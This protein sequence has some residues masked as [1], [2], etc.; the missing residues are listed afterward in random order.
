MGFSKEVREKV[1]NK[2]GGKCAYCGCDLP[3]RWQVDHVVPVERHSMTGEY[4]GDG[5]DSID[6]LLPS[7]QS[8]N[9]IKS[10]QPLES[11]RDELE[12]MYN[13]VYR[14]G[15]FKVA[16]RYRIV[17]RHRINVQ[18]YFEKIGI[19]VVDY[20]KQLLKEEEKNLR[21]ELD[22]ISE[23]ESNPN[24]EWN[25]KIHYNEVER[26]KELIET[27]KLIILSNK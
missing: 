24:T 11:F 12:N 3:N 13:S 27:Y 19:V 15:V 6:N 10:K 23:A 8:C 16:E 18:F 21:F 4:L 9:I 2:T 1:Y 26:I 14:S 22:L 17:E 20:Y 7:C 25:K 5:T